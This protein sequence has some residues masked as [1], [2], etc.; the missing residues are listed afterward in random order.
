MIYVFI[1]TH[2]CTHVHTTF[3][4]YV[5]ESFSWKTA[6]IF[7]YSSA[8]NL[9]CSL[10][11]SRRRESWL[12]SSIFVGRSNFWL[13]LYWPMRNTR[14]KPVL[15]IIP[16]PLHAFTSTMFMFNVHWLIDLL[17]IFQ[18]DEG[19]FSL[20]PNGART[21]FGRLFL[22]EKRGLEVRLFLINYKLSENKKKIVFGW[23]R[24]CGLIVPPTLKLHSKAPHN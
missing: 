24:W 8:L 10:L 15:A 2:T 17:W 4:R 20:N 7:G 13:R 14:Y 5:L 3:L 6:S 9:D 12:H 21:F 18:K 16:P 1:F 22:H 23:F 19:R 11:G